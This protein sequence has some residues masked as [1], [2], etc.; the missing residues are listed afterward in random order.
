ME[1]YVHFPF[2]RKRCPYCDFFSLIKHIDHNEYLELLL[3]EI[4]LRNSGL[5]FNT[6][7]FGG[8]TPSLADPAFFAAIINTV[9]GMK[10]E[11]TMEMN[12]EDI[13]DY[14]LEALK[15]AGVNR[16]SVGI[17]SFDDRGL[18]R[19]QREY[20]G[21]EALEALQKAGGVFDNI[22]SDRIIGFKGDSPELLEE[23]LSMFLANGVEH[24]SVYMLTLNDIQRKNIGSVDDDTMALLY[25]TACE[26]LCKEGWDHYEVSNWTKSKPCAHNL[27]IWSQEN[28]IG[29][30]LGGVGTVDNIRYFNSASMRTY[31]RMLLENIF[32]YEQKEVLSKN[33]LLLEK[34]MLG[35]RTSKGIRQEDYHSLILPGGL[36]YLESEGLVILENGK[37]L[38]TEEGF[39]F[40]NLI[41]EQLLDF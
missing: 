15:K 28:Y 35:M 23:D 9:K 13:R 40:N 38:P 24:I 22:S 3:K 25:R 19:L 30:G 33:T 39:L 8:G 41:L 18:N 14:P 37:I 31:K 6:I 21:K 5:S 29:L 17:Q 32:P 12:P 4:A 27:A 2:C 34:A 10:K 36:E 7:Y 1:L 16:L 20:S 11:I 26:F